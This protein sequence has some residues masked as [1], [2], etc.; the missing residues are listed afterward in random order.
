[1]STAHSSKTMLGCD[2]QLT[3]VEWTWSDFHYLYLVRLCQKCAEVVCTVSLVLTVQHDFR[4]VNF[5]SIHLVL[6]VQHDFSVLYSLLLTGYEPCAPITSNHPSATSNSPLLAQT[7][8]T[9]LSHPNRSLSGLNSSHTRPR[10]SQA[11][12]LL[13]APQ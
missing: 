11:L 4:L 9:T 10:M 7:L 12:Y 2:E 6:T 8:S 1:M 13:L 5:A 3:C